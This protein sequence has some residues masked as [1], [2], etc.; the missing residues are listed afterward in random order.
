[1]AEFDYKTAYS[2]ALEGQAQQYADKQAREEMDLYIQLVYAGNAVSYPS[3]VLK[4]EMFV[5]SSDMVSMGVG[6]YTKLGA[7]VASG[8]SK[9]KLHKQSG[10]HGFT[11]NYANPVGKT[12]AEDIEDRD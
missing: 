11:E 6:T 3:S 9:T 12:I 5:G 10:G 2:M 8:N 7:K 4:V 1:L